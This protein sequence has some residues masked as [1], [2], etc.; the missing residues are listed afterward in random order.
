M[1]INAVAKSVMLYL[2]HDFYNIIFKVTHKLHTALGSVPPKEKFWV[3]ACRRPVITVTV[4]SSVCSLC[5]HSDT[6]MAISG[7]T[8]HMGVFLCFVGVSIIQ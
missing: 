4:L 2:Q 7:P 3:R 1:Y 5:C 6:G 8:W